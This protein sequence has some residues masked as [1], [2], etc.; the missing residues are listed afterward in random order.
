MLRCSR[1]GG[2]AAHGQPVDGQCAHGELFDARFQNAQP[3]DRQGADGY[4][5]NRRR[6]QRQ[7]ADR[8]RARGGFA[9]YR[10][11]DEGLGVEHGGL[12]GGWVRGYFTSDLRR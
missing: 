1:R 11:G 6:A 3:S 10:W 7:R 12:S 9:G 4:G 5:A 2:L 8:Q